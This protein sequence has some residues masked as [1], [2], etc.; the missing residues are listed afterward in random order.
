ML[1]RRIAS[2]WRQHSSTCRLQVFPIIPRPPRKADMPRAC[3]PFRAPDCADPIRQIPYS[4]ES[5]LSPRSSV[6]DDAIKELRAF[7]RELL[8]AFLPVEGPREVLAKGNR[9]ESA[10]RP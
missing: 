5:L 4:S 2:P 9:I 1:F 6:D 8:R 3:H 7:R 10:A